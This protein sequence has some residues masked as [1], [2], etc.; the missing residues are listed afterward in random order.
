[1]R[2]HLP[3]LLRSGIVTVRC[4]IAQSVSGS[5]VSCRWR[6]RVQPEKLERT[7]KALGTLPEVRLCMTTTGSTNLLMTVWVPTLSAIASL[8]Q[9]L[10]KRMP[11]VDIVDSGINLR[12]TKRVGWLLDPAGR[13]TGTVVEPDPVSRTGSVG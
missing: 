5:S 1:V 3:R 7:L 8:E 12:T 2:R 13:S 6:C 4:D 9:L 10:G 11:W